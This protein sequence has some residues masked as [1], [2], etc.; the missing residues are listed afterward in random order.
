MHFKNTN[1]KKEELNRLWS[2][3]IIVFHGNKYPPSITENGDA[4]LN[5]IVHEIHDDIRH[6]EKVMEF[7]IFIVFILVLYLFSVYCSNKY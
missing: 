6:N 2:A 7:N 4:K 3:A 1:F 5:V